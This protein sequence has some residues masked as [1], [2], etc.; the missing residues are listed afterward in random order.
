MR[1]TPGLAKP[2]M[3]VREEVTAVR[4]QLPDSTVLATPDSLPGVPA[5]T[6]AHVLAALRDCLIAHFAC[7]GRTDPNVPTRSQL[8]LTDHQQSP[9]IVAD[10][11]TAL[12]GDAQLAFLS[13][14]RT[15]D[16]GTTELIDEAIHLAS[17]FQLA[18]FPHVIGTL[19]DLDSEAARD[20]T[21]SFYTGLRDSQ[22]HLDPA[23]APLALHTATRD[24]RDA[25]PRSPTLWATHVHVGP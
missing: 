5:P 3:H 17:A 25:Y 9:L 14:C 1:S 7:H 15:A 6:K 12:T 8:L 13:A 10:L 18:D 23:L 21:E 4:R 2:L 20:I 19:W 22:G 24:L 16:A 11:M